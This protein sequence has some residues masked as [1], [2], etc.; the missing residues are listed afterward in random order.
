MRDVFP[1]HPFYGMLL[2]KFDQSLSLLRR[3][4]GVGFPHDTLQVHF[5][6]PCQILVNGV[7][8]KQGLCLIPGSDGCQTR[9]QSHQVVY[10]FTEVRLKLLFF[11]TD[12]VAPVASFGWLL[13]SMGVTLSEKSHV[14]GYG[15]LVAFAV[16]IFYYEVPWVGAIMN[17][18]GLQ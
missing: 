4:H 15:Y 12:A 9:I 18:F 13:L 16:L 10:R 7:R 6:S 5:V 1:Q 2:S 17:T 14:I 3:C 8:G 11:V